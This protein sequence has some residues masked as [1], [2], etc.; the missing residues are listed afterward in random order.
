MSEME[1]MEV[2]GGTSCI[3]NGVE[4]AA[5]VEHSVERVMVKSATGAEVTHKTEPVYRIRLTFEPTGESDGM[6]IFGELTTVWC[7][8][9]KEAAKYARKLGLGVQAIVDAAVKLWNE[10]A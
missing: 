1:R 8:S 9:P 5:S 2:G 3:V 10:A 4:I 7:E 6:G